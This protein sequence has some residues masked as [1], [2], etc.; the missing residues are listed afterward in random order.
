METIKIRGID[1]VI[2][3]TTSKC[4]LPIYVWKNDYAKS[5]YLSLNV[6]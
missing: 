3:F 4:G 2:Y 1:E 5:F 6:Y